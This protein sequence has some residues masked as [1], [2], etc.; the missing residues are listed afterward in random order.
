MPE[1]DGLAATRAIRQWEGEQGFPATPIIALTASALE[2]DVKRSLAAGCDEHVNKPVNKPV[3]LA[4]IRR[5][6]AMRL[7]AAA[8]REQAGAADPQLPRETAVVDTPLA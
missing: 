1:V 7:A 5:A 8:K 4:A 3:L 2:D 6:M